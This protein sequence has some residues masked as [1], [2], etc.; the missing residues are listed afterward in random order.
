MNKGKI[1]QLIREI[2]GR[3]ISEI[4]DEW[5]R[6]D[7][8]LN[9]GW[10]EFCRE[11]R[12]VSRTRLRTC[13]KKAFL[14]YAKNNCSEEQYARLLRHPST[15]KYISRLAAYF[16]VDESKDLVVAL[17]I[18]RGKPLL[19][20]CREVFGTGATSRKAY[21]WLYSEICR[22]YGFDKIP[23]TGKVRV[24]DSA[25]YKFVAANSEATPAE[26]VIE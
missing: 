17:V 13:I 9:Q 11:H 5:I 1:Q 19:E 7:V 15:E 23:R 20:L 25:V 16:Q 12:I 3:D 24:R 18:K 26:C 8:I 21:N 6:E 22:H 2:S 4:V 14:R 10:W